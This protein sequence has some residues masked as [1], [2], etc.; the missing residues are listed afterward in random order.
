[1]CVLNEVQKWCKLRGPAQSVDVLADRGPFGGE[2]GFPNI[3]V[4]PGDYGTNA[5]LK[6]RFQR[7]FP[8]APVWIGSPLDDVREVGIDYPWH[9][10]VDDSQGWYS[11]EI[12]IS[13][14]SYP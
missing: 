10:Q 9:E 14:R 11:G 6:A 3:S 1:M 8:E 7:L 13:N 4:G 2:R 12:E 5:A